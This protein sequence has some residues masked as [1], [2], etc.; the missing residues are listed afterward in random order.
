MEFITGLIATIIILWLIFSSL[1]DKRVI[2]QNLAEAQKRFDESRNEMTA[3]DP[4]Y[5]K[6][7][8]DN[9]WELYR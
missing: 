5:A 6:M 9:F 1:R 8:D 3:L 7:I 2:S 4:E